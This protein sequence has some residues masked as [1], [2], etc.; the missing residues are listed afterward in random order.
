MKVPVVMTAE[1][2]VD[3]VRQTKA[4][5]LE[6]E[7]EEQLKAQVVAATT[8]DELEVLWEAQGGAMFSTFLELFLESYRLGRSIF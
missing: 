5:M 4:L 3:M 8:L 7:Q 1:E 2:A 6:E